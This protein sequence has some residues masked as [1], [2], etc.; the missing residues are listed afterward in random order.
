[1]RDICWLKWLRSVWSNNLYCPNCKNSLIVVDN[2]FF[3]W[4]LFYCKNEKKIF[5]VSFKDVTKLDKKWEFIKGIEK[6]IELEEVKD[7]INYN[8]MEQ[9]KKFLN[10]NK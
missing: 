10:D 4:E 8:N 6:Q 9:I 3:H 1:M 7:E 2:W 5:A